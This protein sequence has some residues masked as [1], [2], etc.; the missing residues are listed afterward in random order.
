MDKDVNI[1]IDGIEAAEWRA[2]KEGRAYLIICVEPDEDEQGCS[3][4][5]RIAAKFKDAAIIMDSLL[6]DATMQD[7]ELIDQLTECVDISAREI[8]EDEADMNYIYEE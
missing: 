6:K 4:S 1:T 2:Q 5:G 3:C 7:S 8:D